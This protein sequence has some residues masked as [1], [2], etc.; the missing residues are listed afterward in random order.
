MPETVLRFHDVSFR[1]AGGIEALHGVS[2]ELFAGQR[3]SIVG[4]NGG[5]KSTLLKL[6]LG[7]LQPSRGDIETC[8][9]P[10]HVGCTLIGYLPQHTVS[11]SMPARVADVVRMGLLKVN[12]APREAVHRALES[13]NAA[14]LSHRPFAALS[15][16][17]RQRVLLA[18]ALVDSPRVLFLDEPVAH[19]DP[20][21]ANH[22]RELMR[23][24][25]RELTVVTVT[26]DLTFV[27]ADTELAL[28]VNRTVHLHPTE[29]LGAGIAHVFESPVARVRHDEE[30]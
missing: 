13:V 19:L 22:F 12:K 1:Y 26:H 24:L 30:L 7:L 9:H 15:G 4:P 17:Q 8:G 16:G 25:D 11:P 3:V 20:E 5:G 14:D 28:C 29:Q 27:E 10:P 2:F 21:A 23:G 18:R 6:A